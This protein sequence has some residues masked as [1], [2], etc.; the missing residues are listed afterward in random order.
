MINQRYCPFCK[1]PAATGCQ[2]LALATEGRDF[3]RRCI[4]LCQGEQ[5]WR[6]LCQQRHQ[7]TVG[8]WSPAHADFT[9]L[10]TAFCEEFLQHLTWFGGMD[11]EWR[12]GP[13]VDQGGFWVLL[14]SKNPRQLWWE[15]REEIESECALPQATPETP[16]WLIWLNPK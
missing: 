2:H 5:V 13:R 7:Q 10:E 14:W 11:H 4:E 9:W 15:L 8:G 3:V 6:L 12:S 16:P 1:T